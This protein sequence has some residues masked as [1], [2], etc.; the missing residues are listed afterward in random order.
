M[1]K[2]TE[3]ILD[4]IQG[5]RKEMVEEPVDKSKCDYAINFLVQALVKY[6]NTVQA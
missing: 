4:Q 6:Q 3:Y 1:D 5:L 2:Y